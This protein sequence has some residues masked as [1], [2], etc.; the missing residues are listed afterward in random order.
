MLHF[1]STFGFSLNNTNFIQWIATFNVKARYAAS[2]WKAK[3]ST[4]MCH[5]TAQIPKVF[6]YEVNANHGLF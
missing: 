6:S 5:L 1:H 2:F 3:L 4:L